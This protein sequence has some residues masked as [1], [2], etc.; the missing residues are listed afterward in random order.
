M[1]KAIAEV[2]Q[3]SGDVDGKAG[4]MPMGVAVASAI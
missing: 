3:L 1:D 2:R 4:T